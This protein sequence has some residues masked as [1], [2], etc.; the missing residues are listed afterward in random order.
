MAIEHE[1]LRWLRR[2][3]VIAACDRLGLVPA[4]A[5]AARLPEGAAA[6]ALARAAVALELASGDPP[7]WHGELAAI[8]T[9]PERWQ[10]LVALIDHQASYLG[11]VASL[12]VPASASQTPEAQLTAAPG[13]YHGFL[14]GVDV[15][16]RRH[17]TWLAALPALA[18][19]TTLSDIGAGLGTFAWAWLVSDPRRR[20]VLLDLPAVV[21]SPPEGIASDRWRFVG[22]D[23]RGAPPLPEGDLLLFANVLH[24]FGPALRA[25]IIAA[26]SRAL[27]AG[28]RVAIFEADPDGDAGALFDLQV[29]LRSGFEGGLLAASE[30]EALLAAAGTS[31]IE[32]HDTADP[33]DPFGRRYRLWIGQMC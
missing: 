15:S 6:A 19:T 10:R 16:H 33:D 17:A 28:G 8:A 32:R 26:A 4:L 22:A 11:L 13:A 2:A 5:G 29:R 21:P 1:L 30:V 20:A 14:R 25:A 27:G 31:M 9:A 24:L 23:L 7:H 12:G 18:S 3:T